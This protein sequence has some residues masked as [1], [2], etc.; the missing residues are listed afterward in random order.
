[1]AETIITR[2]MLVLPVKYIAY[3]RV[4]FLSLTD[5]GPFVTVCLILNVGLEFPIK[6]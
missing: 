6:N 4:V 3:N 2:V 1:M 5:G